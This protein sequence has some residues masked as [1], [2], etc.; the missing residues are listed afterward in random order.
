LVKMNK[1][2][3][4]LGTGALVLA[5]NMFGNVAY[6]S[7]SNNNN[8]DNIRKEKEKL[9]SAIDNT[10]IRLDLL[11]RI[12]CNSGKCLEVKLDLEGALRSHN[13]E[14]KNKDDS[15]EEL[16]EIYRKSFERAFVYGYFK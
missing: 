5:V 3:K 11:A 1:L 16:A 13:R 14:I 7:L 2:Q 8:Y 6:T 12:D 10:Q 9:L 15:L 4:T